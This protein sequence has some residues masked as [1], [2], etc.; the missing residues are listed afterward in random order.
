MI[1]AKEEYAYLKYSDNWNS[2]NVDTRNQFTIGVVMSKLKC[3][4][5]YNK[6]GDRNK[7]V[8]SNVVRIDYPRCINKEI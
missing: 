5:G 2:I 8:N 6:H 4:A 1:K 3:M 7:K